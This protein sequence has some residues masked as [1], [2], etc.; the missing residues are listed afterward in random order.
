[1]LSSSLTEVCDELSAAPGPVPMDFEVCSH[2]CARRA[3][4]T[5]SVYASAAAGK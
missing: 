4:L 1:M 5:F 3:Y 2:K